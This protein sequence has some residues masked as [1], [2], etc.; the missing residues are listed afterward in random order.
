MSYDDGRK[1]KSMEPFSKIVPFFM[2]RRTG[3]QVFTKDQVNF[4]PIYEFMDQ[5]SKEG[6]SINYLSLFVAA[7]VR[8]LA[9]RPKLN[10]FV[11][12]NKIYARRGIQVSMVVKKY[13]QDDAQESTVK[14]EFNGTENVFE[15]QEIITKSIK[16]YHDEKSNRYL[17]LFVDNLTKWPSFLLN[18][19]IGTIRFLDRK[20][21]LPKKLIAA[22]PFHSSIFI[23][24]LKS[25]KQGFVYHHLYDIGTASVFVAIGKESKMAVLEGDEVVVKTVSEIGYTIDERICDGLYLSNSMRYL[26]TILEDPSVLRQSLEKIEEDQD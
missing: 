17:D 8:L 23:S 13:L 14:F 6:H 26:K 22:S 3:A 10:R 11:R 4:E 2:Q 15:I 5:C 18:P 20:A 9:V 25:I 1:I 12:D 24:Y 19:I 21:L 7:Y 16:E